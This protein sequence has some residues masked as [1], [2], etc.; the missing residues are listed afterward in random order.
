MSDEFTGSALAF[1]SDMIKPLILSQQ[2]GDSVR[3]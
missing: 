3:M 1:H 2:E